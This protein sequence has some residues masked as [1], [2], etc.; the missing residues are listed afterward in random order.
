MKHFFIATLIIFTIS[1]VAFAQ[2]KD[3]TNKLQNS[4]DIEE[5]FKREHQLMQKMLNEFFDDQFFDRRGFNS[6]PFEDMKKMREKMRNLF[7]ENNNSFDNL[8]DSW[9]GDKFGG[10]MGEIKSH[11]DK[12]SVYYE[13][14]ID[15]I[16]KES[17]NIKVEN[18]IVKIS[19][20]TEILTQKED[21]KTKSKSIQ[22]G[23]FQ[24]SYPVPDN[25]DASK[26]IIESKDN[27]VILKFPKT[28][29]SIKKEEN[30]YQ[31]G[32]PI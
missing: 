27:K 5:I 9:Y 10:S 29:E 31:G 2:T 11:E 3:K 32:Q 25:V 20:K 17:L 22:S 15:N 21:G 14:D 12:N 6:D 7:N 30:Y 16:N 19:G 24:R 18:N 8:F 13:L 26:V 28:K 4:Q 1:Q 23:Q